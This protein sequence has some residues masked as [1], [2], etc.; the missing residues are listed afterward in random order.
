MAG[1][2][3]V[4]PGT[5]ACFGYTA[6]A[7]KTDVPTPNN[8]WPR[9]LST[10]Y[11]SGSWIEQNLDIWDTV[12]PHLGQGVT[13]TANITLTKAVA[14]GTTAPGD[15]QDGVVVG[16]VNGDTSRSVELHGT[17]TSGTT[18]QVQ[19]Q[20]Q[21]N[22]SEVQTWTTLSNVIWVGSTW[23]GVLTLPKADEWWKTNL[24]Y[25]EDTSDALGF[26]TTN[27]VKWAVGWKFGFIGQSQL[28]RWDSHRHPTTPMNFVA[29]M[30]GLVSRYQW[31]EYGLNGSNTGGGRIHVDP[32]QRG[33]AL[34]WSRGN[35]KRHRSRRS[36]AD[37]VR[38]DVLARYGYPA[39]AR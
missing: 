14:P 4:R 18:P 34:G 28:S 36:D 10:V 16:L 6:E 26:A 13:P 32:D 24:R 25:L 29:A 39:A 35:R 15:V 21:S 38:Q 37:D 17:G 1:R 5:E 31:F 7:A 19:I 23:S 27:T 8:D 2:G 30:D 9:L 20:R 22:S 12:Q 3:Q 33:S 11:Y